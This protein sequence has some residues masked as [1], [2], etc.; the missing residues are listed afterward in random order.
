M[1]E[2]QL[3]R[4]MVA[5]VDDEDYEQLIQLSWYAR[6]GR[7]TWYAATGKKVAGKV[8][9]TM[10]H[11][12]ILGSGCDDEVDH[13]NHNGLD[14]RRSNIRIATGTQN[15]Q[16]RMPLTGGTSK[17][18]G[19]CFYKQNRKWMA[20]IRIDRRGVHLGYFDDETDAAKAYDKAA[21]KYFSQFALTNAQAFGI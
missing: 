21:I 17:Y 1:R 19:V 2:I 14:N 6:K 9:H 10:M 12:L 3:T 8:V 5:I 15:A 16:N 4:G 11:C 20:Y 18:K 7:T 13:Q